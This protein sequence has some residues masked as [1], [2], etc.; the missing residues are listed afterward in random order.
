MKNTWIVV[1]M[2]G[3]L[4][5]GCVPAE[6]TDAPKVQRVEVAVTE[7]GFVLSQTNI[8]TGQPVTL[9]V[10]RKVER[11]CA[12]DAVIKEF[13]INKPLPLN[14]PVEVTFTPKKPGQIRLACGMD[15]IAAELTAE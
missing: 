5:A 12:T 7:D 4:T 9:V 14:E 6:D 11:T 8:K 3:L 1:V 10:T 2:T 13:G 15:M